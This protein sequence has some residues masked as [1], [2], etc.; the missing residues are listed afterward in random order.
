M[1]VVSPVPLRVRSCADAHYLP[2]GAADP[3]PLVTARRM[4]KFG[5]RSPEAAEVLDVANEHTVAV[6][7]Q[8]IHGPRGGQAVPLVCVAESHG[9]CADSRRRCA[10]MP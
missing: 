8:R 4:G 3:R 1:R 5:A 7:E 10:A 2:T 9:R 6:C